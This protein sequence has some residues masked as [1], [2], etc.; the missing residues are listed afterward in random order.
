MTASVE[1]TPRAGRCAGLW[2]ASRPRWDARDR[3]VAR[4]RHDHPGGDPLRVAA[5]AT[6]VVASLAAVLGCAPTGEGASAAAP[7]S[8]LV[9]E[10]QP[11]GITCVLQREQDVEPV[12]AFHG[13]LARPPGQWRSGRMARR[14]VFAVLVDGDTLWERGTHCILAGNLRPAMT[15][16]TPLISMS[17]FVPRSA[18]SGHDFTIRSSG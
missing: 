7:N 2:T 3:L 12:G 1:P 15:E 17:S 11:A 5:G 4:E 18:V 14:R 16:R 6:R 9:V 8:A 13:V 10:R